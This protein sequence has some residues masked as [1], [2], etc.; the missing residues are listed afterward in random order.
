MFLNSNSNIYFCVLCNLY[1]YGGSLNVIFILCFEFKYKI[2]IFVYCATFT[3]TVKG[4]IMITSHILKLKLEI[5]IPVHCVTFTHTVLS[6]KLTSAHVL[7]SKLEIC[8]FVHCVTFTH[9]VIGLI[10]YLAYGH[11]SIL[12]QQFTQNTI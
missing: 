9:P 5:H 1:S 6:L 7:K 8:I 12:F 4:S 10:L 2:K 3:R 11:P